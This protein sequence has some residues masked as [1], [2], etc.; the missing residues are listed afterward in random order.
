MLLVLKINRYWCCQ[1]VIV[2]LRIASVFYSWC[3]PWLPTPRGFGG[4]E[5]FYVCSFK[6]SRLGGTEWFVFFWKGAVDLIHL[7][8]CAL[9]DQKVLLIVKAIHQH[10]K[11][12]SAL[13]G[14]LN[15]SFA[16]SGKVEGLTV[17]RLLPQFFLLMLFPPC[18]ILG[19]LR[20]RG[21]FL[22]AL[23]WWQESKEPSKK[24]VM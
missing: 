22:W 12:V 24:V 4:R 7:N 1:V 9:G 11:F 18:G 5:H 6:G 21:G 20:G 3:W 23:T 15:P 16:S 13:L 8:I 17:W 14:G 19:E 2:V 10:Q